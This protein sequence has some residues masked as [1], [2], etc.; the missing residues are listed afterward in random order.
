MPL[1]TETIHEREEVRGNTHSHR[2]RRS[3]TRSL[4]VG[5]WPGEVSP[6]AGGPQAGISRQEEEMVFDRVRGM[7]F[8]KQ[9]LDT[10]EQ[11]CCLGE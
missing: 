11:R 7:K 5:Y 6:L 4:R 2:N 9:M 3:R 8:Y 10:T 1:L